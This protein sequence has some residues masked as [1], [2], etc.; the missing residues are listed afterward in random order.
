MKKNNIIPTTEELGAGTLRV[1]IPAGG[2]LHKPAMEIFRNAELPIT[3]LH[4]RILFGEGERWDGLRARFIRPRDIAK[5][6]ANGKLDIGIT[7]QNI[8]Y[9]TNVAVHELL[10]LDFGKCR[11]VVAALKSNNEPSGEL[12]VATSYPNISRAYF[13]EHCREVDIIET[14][15]AVEVYPNMGLAD[16]IVDV[17]QTG[18]TL[19]ENG[20][21]ITAEI[22]KSRAV[23]IASYYLNEKQG[24]YANF[25]KR[26]FEGAMNAK[27]YKK[28]VCRVSHN[29]KDLLKFYNIYE[30]Y[31]KKGW[32]Y[33]AQLQETM[34]DDEFITFEFLC[35]QKE[36][37]KIMKVLETGKTGTLDGIGEGKL[38]IQVENISMLLK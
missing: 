29:A 6:T 28:V 33:V 20:L 4:E 32:E 30:Y 21:E 11:M 17:T 36:V 34:R 15:G 14:G 3:R 16:A 37:S 13:E 24:E 18:T 31:E 19:N 27:K 9:E 25:I 8:I 35:T 1:G 7:T 2:R 26:S 23:L 5:F 38:T 12:C 10:E 22:M